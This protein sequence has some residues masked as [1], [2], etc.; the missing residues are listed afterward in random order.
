MNWI[1]KHMVRVW[2]NKE[3][4]QLP[5]EIHKRILQTMVN[6]MVSLNLSLFQNVSVSTYIIKRLCIISER[7]IVTAL[8]GSVCSVQFLTF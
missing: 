3:F 4:S 7:L 5:D 6:S 8:A 2:P 1:V